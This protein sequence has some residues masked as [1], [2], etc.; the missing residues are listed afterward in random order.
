MTHGWNWAIKKLEMNAEKKL[1][2]HAWQPLKIGLP[3]QL[4]T[5]H[6]QMARFLSRN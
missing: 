5:T 2:D 3:A 4:R 1:D 6:I